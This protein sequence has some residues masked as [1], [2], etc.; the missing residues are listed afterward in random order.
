MSVGGPALM[1]IFLHYLGIAAMI[2]FVAGLFALSRRIPYLMAAALTC[3]LIYL[4]AV[5]FSDAFKYQSAGDAVLTRVG[6]TVLFGVELL[7]AFLIAHWLGTRL[8]VGL[9]WIKDHLQ[10]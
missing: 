5:T 8:R 6:V 7:F 10:E 9:A 2:P 1:A 4:Q 3:G